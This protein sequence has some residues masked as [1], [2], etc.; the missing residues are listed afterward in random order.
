MIL[1]NKNGSWRNI[2]G[3]KLLKEKQRGKNLNAIEKLPMEIIVC[4]IFFLIRKQVL[5]AK[6]K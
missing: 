6:L 4:G 3:Y 2:F 5:S 1:I